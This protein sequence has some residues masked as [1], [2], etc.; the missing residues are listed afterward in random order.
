[1]NIKKILMNNNE[2][3]YVKDDNKDYHLKF[4]IIDQKDLKKGGLVKSSINRQYYAFNPSFIDQYQKIKR[5]AQIIPNKDLGLIISKTGL[6]KDSIVVDAGAGS[7]GVACFLANI[8]KKVYT[9]D[10][11]KE[12]VEIVKKNVTDLELKNV[13]VIEHDITKPISVKNADV[14]ILDIAEPWTALNTVNNAL[15]VGGFLIGYVPTTTQLQELNNT[16][17]QFKSLIV[18]ENI[19]LIAREWKAEGKAVRPLTG[20]LHSGFLTIVRK[21]V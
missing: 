20:T 17:E 5:G 7:G 14:F 12:N 3:H 21:V 19:E 9:Y 11:K 4:G 2:K 18:L 15:K 16:L 13:E 10:I 8:V 1:M 6:G